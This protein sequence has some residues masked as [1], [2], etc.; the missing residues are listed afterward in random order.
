MTSKQRLPR[1][2]NWEVEHA[3]LLREYTTWLQSNSLNSTSTAIDT[4]M[5]QVTSNVDGL[6]DINDSNDLDQPTALRRGKR[7][8]DAISPSKPS[9]P[10]TPSKAAPRKRNRLSDPASS[11]LTPFVRRATLQTPRRRASTP[12]TTQT[13]PLELHF[14]PLRQ[15]L[16]DRTKRRIRRNGLSEEMNAYESERKDKAQLQKELHAKDQE[17]LELKTEL[18]AA[19]CAHGTIHHNSVEELASS[20][21]T[22]EAEIEHLRQSFNEASVPAASDEDMDINWDHVSAHT[23]GIALAPAPASDGGDTIPI[24]EDDADMFGPSTP[25]GK[26]P[27]QVNTAA[28]EEILAM[29]LDLESAK[30]GKRQLFK[31]VRAHLPAQ[32]AV[33]ST[34]L[35]HGLSLHFEDSPGLSIHDGQEKQPD[36]T[37]STI[38]LPSPPKTFYADLAKALKSTT[39]RAESAELAL[40]SLEVDLYTLGFTPSDEDSSTTSILENIRAHF[41]QSRLELE[42]VC[43]GETASGLNDTAAVLPEAISKLKLLSRRVQEREAELRSMHEQQRTLK[44]NFECS[45]RAAEKANQ[46]IKELEDAVEE[47]ADDLLNMRMKLQANEKD[48]TEKEHTITSLIAALEKYRADVTRLEG[49][50]IQLENEQSFHLQETRDADAQKIEELEVKAGAETTGRRKAE[51]S[52]ITRL[53]QINE[54]TTSLDTANSTASAL[55]LQLSTL[56]AQLLASSTAFTQQHQTLTEQHSTQLQNLTTRLASL[57]TALTASDAENTRLEARVAKLRSRSR[58]SAD[59]STHTVESIWHEQ[60]RS[61]TKC[62]ELR[63]SYVR[64]CKVRDANWELEDEDEEADRTDADAG[65]EPMTPVS[66][67]RFVD[68]EEDGEG[69]SPTTLDGADDDHVPGSVQIARGRGRLARSNG[70]IGGAPA[71]RLGFAMGVQKLKGRRRWRGSNGRRRLDSGIG[72]GC[73]SEEDEG[74]GDAEGD[75]GIGMGCLSEEDEGEA[76]AEGDSGFGEVVSSHV[77]AAP[78]SLAHGGEEDEGFDIHEDEDGD[79]GDENEYAG[80]VVGQEFEV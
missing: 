48:T 36:F 13:K 4:T 60:V 20:Q 52:A 38:S 2:A 55:Q 66:L 73:L 5:S 6:N 47:G 21:R 44:G 27:N 70:C 57:T 49:L 32:Q 10:L 35:N 19:K 22:V 65:R 54:L 37:T 1:S 75:S 41:R 63:K 51:E 24:Y 71:R 42:R 80:G 74:E 58:V 12:A 23:H 46:R 43:P 8:S 68:V 11:G 9:A 39:D 16:D 15:K 18:E 33:P 26:H 61:V 30:R 72:M 76:D 78:P 79:C 50:V 45:L 29:A 62:A 31:D 34:S 53:A 69:S 64:G 14:T 59:A 56:E 3:Q 7:R 25:S 17:L 28:D 77:L 40:Y 67:V